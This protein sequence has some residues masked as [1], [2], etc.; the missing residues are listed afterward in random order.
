MSGEQEVAAALAAAH[1]ADAQY[2]QQGLGKFIAE[3]H[4][5]QTTGRDWQGAPPRD[6]GNMGDPEGG[7]GR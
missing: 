4:M 1:R 6:P 2:Q 5:S 7:E 3:A